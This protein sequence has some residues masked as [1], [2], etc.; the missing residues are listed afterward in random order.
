M[1]IKRGF[2]LFLSGLAIMTA[3][4]IAGPMPDP[5]TIDQDQAAGLSGPARH[6]IQKPYPYKPGNVLVDDS[7]LLP[8]RVQHPAFYGCFDWHS[9]VHGHWTLVRLL[10]EY[11][12]LPESELIRGMLAENLSAENIII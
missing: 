3:C 8:P 6:C 12:G 7:T 4:N 11:P 1:K 9:S 5:I 10:K 2:F